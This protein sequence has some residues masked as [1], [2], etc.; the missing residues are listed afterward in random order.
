M[1]IARSL[2][3]KICITFFVAK[4]LHGWIHNKQ[5]I[6]KWQLKNI[7]KI[8]D[9]GLIYLI[10]A[11]S[12]VKI[13]KEDEKPNRRESWSKPGYREIPRKKI[14]ENQEEMW[15]LI[16]NKRN[17]NQNNNGIQFLTM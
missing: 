9:K 17:A 10:Y 7:W 16:G 15:N 4:F 14:T 12:K 1:I 13:R 3:G 11:E 6:I 5:G 8:A 2:K